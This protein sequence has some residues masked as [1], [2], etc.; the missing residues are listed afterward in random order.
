MWVAPLQLHDKRLQLLIFVAFVFLTLGATVGYQ[1]GVNRVAKAR[2][3]SAEAAQ[4]S[5]KVESAETRTCRAAQVRAQWKAQH[6]L[7]ANTPP[8]ECPQ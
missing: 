8:V 4:V 7:L 3:S 6:Y 1:L 2:R 5:D